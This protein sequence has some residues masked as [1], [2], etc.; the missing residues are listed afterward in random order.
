MVRLYK[1]ASEQL[2]QQEHYDFGMRALKSVLATAGSL[3]RSSAGMTEHC[4]NILLVGDTAFRLVDCAGHSQVCLPDS[5][6]H[7]NERR[8]RLPCTLQF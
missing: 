2:S 4:L 7:T 3:K 6:G 1:L 8:M 5:R